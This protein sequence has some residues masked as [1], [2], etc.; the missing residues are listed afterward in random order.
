LE[1]IVNGAL[2]G[3][4]NYSNAN[5]SISQPPSQLLQGNDYIVL[6]GVLGSTIHAGAGNDTI[7][8][9]LGNDNIF[10]GAGNDT[11]IGFVGADTINGGPG[12][13]TI[14]L[15]A[16]SPDLNSASDAQIVNV[17]AISA[18]MA[19]TGVTIDLH[20]QTEGFTITGS[21]YD[22][23]I[24]GSSGADIIY[25]GAGNDTIIGFVG[26]DTI[27]GGAG[28]DTLVLAATSA[29]LNSASDVQ[30]VNVEAVS[31]ATATSG[32]TINLHHQTEGFTITGSDY[33][34]TITGGSGNDTIIGFVGADTI[35][36]GPGYDTIVLTATSPDLNSASDAQIV[37]VEAISAATAATGVT[38]DLHNQTEGFTIT[39]SGYADT[40]T[41]SSGNDTIIGF[42]GA[43]TINGGPG[44]DRIKLTAT[45]IDLNSASDAQIVNVEAISVATAA[46]SV[47]IDLHI[48][49]CKINCILRAN[50]I[51]MSAVSVRGSVS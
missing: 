8:G 34:D 16:T 30:I 18:A 39:G 45:S 33:A 4:E 3:F 51:I 41:G 50:H 43:D 10:G 42:L 25:A 6:S 35:N 49:C 1:F 2:N 40:I 15:T 17:E 19:A 21:G 26:H 13:D 28:Y 23:T 48:N 11:I 22:D 32:V 47:T 44:Y 38:I 27:K 5:F 46:T 20:N 29:D 9:S 37:N 31:A 24:T 14:K 7:V 12:Y 36:G